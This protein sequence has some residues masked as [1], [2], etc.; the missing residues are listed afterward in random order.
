MIR[1]KKLYVR[2]RKLYEKKRIAEENA[3]L[4]KYGLKNKREV[5]KALAKVNYYRHRA[6]A[7]AKQSQEEQKVLFTKLNAI[8]LPVKSIADI[9]ALKV[10]DILQRRLPTIVFKQK[11]AQTPQQARQMV[12]HKKVLID[13]KAVDVP[14]YLVHVNEETHITV[15]ASRP[16]KPKEAQPE[17]AQPAQAAPAKEAG[18]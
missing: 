9:L 12:V 2:P 15:K 1:K 8:G 3:L 18:A 10:E 4:E 13:G 7:L 6:M 5:W 14:S 16:K 17:Q 11:L